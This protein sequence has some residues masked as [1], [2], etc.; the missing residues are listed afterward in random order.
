M[1]KRKNVEEKEHMKLHID[2]KGSLLRDVIAST[3]D[4]VKESDLK[5]IILREKLLSAICGDSIWSLMTTAFVTE[6]IL[7]SEGSADVELKNLERLMSDQEAA[8]ML[9][10]MIRFTPI[11][12][13]DEKSKTRFITL[14]ALHK[15]V[16]ALEE[17]GK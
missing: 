9:K 4:I 3:V 10:L 15:A 6:L 14:L 11:P 2:L 16:R 8:D 1:L 13:G 5:M 12:R 7:E 17:R